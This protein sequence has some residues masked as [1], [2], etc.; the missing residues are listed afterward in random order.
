MGRARWS[1]GT[2]DVAASYYAGH[3]TTPLTGPDIETD[4]TRI[5]FDT[6]LYFTTPR[7]GGASLKAEGYAGHE[8]NPDSVKVIV[9]GSSGARLLVPGRNPDH[10]ATDFRGG[11]LMFVQ[12]A[13][14]RVQFAARY[15]A[16]D[17]NIDLDH[18]QYRRVSLG[19][20]A[21]YDAFTRLTV[22]YDAITTEVP[23]GG[24]RYQDPHDNLWTFQLQHKF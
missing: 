1:E 6:Q 9:S 8:V 7:V 18:D 23:A 11:Y 3:Q 16:W 24:G 12:N 22:S 10:I 19:L 4:K 13:G 17:P 2:W 14:E 21:F 5:G 15:D 20:N